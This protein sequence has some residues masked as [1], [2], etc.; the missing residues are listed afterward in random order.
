MTE[1]NLIRLVDMLHQTMKE[2][3]MTTPEEIAKEDRPLAVPVAPIIPTVKEKDVLYSFLYVKYPEIAKQA[4][5][6]VE[7]RIFFSKETYQKHLDFV[8]L[9]IK[10]RNEL[11]S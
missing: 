2:F 5:R 6:I 3:G 7:S 11:S 4:P 9:A 10:I 8:K 1:Y